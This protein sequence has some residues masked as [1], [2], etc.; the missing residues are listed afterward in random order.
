MV[1]GYWGWNAGWIGIGG[2][3]VI[4]PGTVRIGW[5]ADG[6]GMDGDASGWAGIGADQFY[7]S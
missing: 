2:N 7:L 1:Q 6:P 5:A 4:R 3:W